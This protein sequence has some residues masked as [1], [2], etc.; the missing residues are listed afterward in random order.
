MEVKCFCILQ[1]I[2]AN[3]VLPEIQVGQAYPGSRFFL[4]VL[5]AQEDPLFQ[6]RRAFQ[7]R[8]ELQVGQVDPF[9]LWDQILQLVPAVQQRQVFQQGLA[10]HLLLEHLALLADRQCHPEFPNELSG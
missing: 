9:H 10:G 1:A 7:I 5:G 4:D 3:H 8:L 6:P 2:L